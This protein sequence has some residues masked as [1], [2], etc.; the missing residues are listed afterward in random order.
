MKVKA[1]LVVTDGY[2]NVVEVEIGRQLPA[3]LAIEYG[4]PGYGC[5]V[6]D[7]NG[8]SRK[9]ITEVLQLAID[10]FNDQVDALTTKKRQAM[11]DK[12]VAKVA[13]GDLKVDDVAAAGHTRLAGKLRGRREEEVEA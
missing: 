12:I 6:M 10:Q 13:R 1:T 9:A 4:E 7:F 5:P 2:N 8:E 11:E 3:P